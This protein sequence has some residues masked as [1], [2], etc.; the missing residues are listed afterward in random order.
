C[1][2]AAP[3]ALSFPTRRSSDLF[4]RG[5]QAAVRA[6][7]G[8]GA[9]E[10][11]RVEARRFHPD[12]VPQQRAARERAGG[13]DRH[14]ADRESLSPVMLDEPRSEEHTSELQSPYDLVCRL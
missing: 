1:S 14:D 7:R 4:G 12:A 5:G 8:H 2:G 11:V 13:V 9:D 6:P 3:Y 10:D